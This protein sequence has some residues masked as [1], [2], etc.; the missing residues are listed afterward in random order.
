M[1]LLSTLTPIR[2][3]MRFCIGS[4]PWRLIS[5]GASQDK[6]VSNSRKG[7]TLVE[8]LVILA[9][10][11][12]IIGLGLFLSFDFYKNYAF[13]SEGTTIVSI[14]QKARSQ[15]INNIDETRHGVHFATSPLKYIIFECK[16]A[17]PQCSSY[18]DADT[19]KDISMDSSYD[20][21]LSGGVDIVFTQLEGSCVGCTT[22]PDTTITISHDSKSYNIKINGEGKID[23]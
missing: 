12:V 14:L 16:S 8:V 9:I 5:N 11:L 19:A 4:R 7:F 17:I 1:E 2:N 23:W 22:S 3:S 20:V 13:Y 15:S 21:L 18:T 10:L 6:K